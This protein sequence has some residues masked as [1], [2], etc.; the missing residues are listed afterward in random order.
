MFYD[1]FRKGLVNP[2]DNGHIPEKVL[3]P[4]V[5]FRYEIREPYMMGTNENSAY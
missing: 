3:L 5:L 1:H 2:L 4:A